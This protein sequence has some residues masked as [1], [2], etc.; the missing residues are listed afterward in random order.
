M[1]NDVQFSGKRHVSKSIEGFN[2]LPEVFTKD[3]VIRVFHYDKPRAADKKIER[4]K[5]DN[6]I[7]RIAEGDDFGK[8]RKQQTVF[9]YLLI[10]FLFSLRSDKRSF[11]MYFLWFSDKKTSELY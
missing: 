2:Q 11:L 3:D 6:F 4:L 1:N 8:Y 7:E 10:V 5:A 9:F